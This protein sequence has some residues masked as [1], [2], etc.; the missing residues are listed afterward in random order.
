MHDIVSRGGRCLIPVFALGR[1]QELLLILDEYW[2]SHPELH[3]IPIY[4]GSSLAKKCMNVYK[5]FLTS[6]NDR[7][8]RQAAISNPFNFKYISNIKTFDDIGPSV[9]LASPGMMQSGLSRELFESWC[10]D[11]KNG[12]IIAGYCV[13]NTLAKQILSETTEI[14]SMSGKK[15]PV[16]MQVSSISFSAHTDYDSSSEFIRLL[17]PSHIILV[18]GEPAEMNRLKLALQREYE[19][20]EEIRFQLHTPRNT[21]EVDLSFRGEKMAKVMGTL[22]ASEPEEGKALSGILIKRGFKHHLVDPDDLSKYTDLAIST[23]KQQQTVAFQGSLSALKHLLQ[24]I[25]PT[26]KSVSHQNREA[27]VVFN[28][29]TVIK[30][31][32]TLTLEWIANAVNDMYADA[33]LTVILQVETNPLSIQASKQTT[34]P[35]IPNPD[36]FPKRLIRLYREMFGD[37]AVKADLRDPSQPIRIVVDDKIA[38]VYFTDMVVECEDDQFSTQLLNAMKRLSA[39]LVPLQV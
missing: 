28:E 29:I 2:A 30:E 10:A 37:S 26:V 18:H 11:R 33:V 19:D 13:E 36:L 22:A 5:T 16:K 9:V 24:Q 34:L 27:L 21:Q 38:F 14:T 7:I 17:K 4:Y 39:A 1:A 3:E 31:D 32:K 35:S 23:V 25:S 6:M 20:N 15:L 8:N 12:V